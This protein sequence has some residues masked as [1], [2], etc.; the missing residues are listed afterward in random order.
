MVPFFFLYD[1][2]YLKYERYRSYLRELKQ[3]N[4][5]PSTLNNPAASDLEG[6]KKPY[7]EKYPRGTDDSKGED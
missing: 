1:R 5:R 3:K 2:Y 6:V 7:E 4:I